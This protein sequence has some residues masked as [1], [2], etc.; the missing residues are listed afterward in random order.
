MRPLTLIHKKM[1]SRG[2]HSPTNEF[3]VHSPPE[4][5]ALDGMD[6]P[7][8]SAQI[9][10][11]H[12]T[13]TLH[14]RTLQHVSQATS[15]LLHTS[16]HPTTQCVLPCIS[17]VKPFSKF[18]PT[19]ASKTMSDQHSEREQDWTTPHTEGAEISGFPS[20]SWDRVRSK[21]ERQQVSM[22]SSW[23]KFCTGL[24]PRQKELSLRIC[25]S[26]ALGE[27]VSKRL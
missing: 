13:T 10:M 16:A 3:T 18:T 2:R 27:I 19:T 17:R 22:S 8:S 20:G 15:P 7:L 26:P 11:F 21:R 24:L 1:D 9:L 12:L 25:S 14:T 4:E 23:W 5:Q 6:F